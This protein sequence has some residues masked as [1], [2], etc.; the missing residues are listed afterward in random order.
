M[1]NMCELSLAYARGQSFENTGDFQESGWGKDAVKRRIACLFLAVVLAAALLGGCTDTGEPAVTQMGEGTY[2]IAIITGTTSQGEEEYRAAEGMKQMYGDRIV[3]SVYPD[4][5]AQETEVTMQRVQEL[6][7]DPDVKVLIF[8]Q[9][10]VG[11]KAAVEKARETRDDILYLCGIPGE[12]PEQIASAADVVLAM[13]VIG[14]GNVLIQ[15][16]K[17]MGA[18]TFVHAPFPGT[19]RRIW[20]SGVMTC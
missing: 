13:D 18:K 3:T 9:A 5:A 11:A 10:V 1:Q 12:D 20:E 2:K 4:N 19:W 14:V 15:Q 6:I 16:A 17:A 7:A 8:C